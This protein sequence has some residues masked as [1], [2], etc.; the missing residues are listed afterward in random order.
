[1]RDGGHARRLHR[2]AAASGVGR[3]P[4][5]PL[6]CGRAIVV[7]EPAR[8]PKAVAFVG[9]DGKPVHL[10]HFKGKVVLLNFWAAWCAACAREIPS[11]DALAATAKGSH[12]AVVPVSVDRGGL[13]VARAFY[14]KHDVS[15][16]PLYSDGNLMAAWFPP[17]NP[18]SAPFMLNGLPK[19]FLV[20]RTGR[21]RGYVIG[22]T[23]WTSIQARQLLDF[24]LNGPGR[25]T[26]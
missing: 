24:C 12:L 6:Q 7:E 13:P 22:E 23:D 26:P 15:H 19:T 9:P 1:L 18:N 14:R 21:V 11:L 3:L 17:D 10:E 4:A 2:V 5:G 16:L 8:K 20:D 25:P